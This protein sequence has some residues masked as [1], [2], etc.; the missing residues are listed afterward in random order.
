[1][2]TLARRIFVYSAL[3]LVKNVCMC[4]EVYDALENRLDFL[5]FEI[6]TKYWNRISRYKYLYNCIFYDCLFSLFIVNNYNI[7]TSRKVSNV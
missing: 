6:D 3:G 7:N 1:M 5:E 2:V 4:V